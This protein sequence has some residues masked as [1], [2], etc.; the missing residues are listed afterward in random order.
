ML[1]RRRHP[2]FLLAEPLDGSVLLREEVSIERWHGNEL[3]VLSPD[4]GR[5]QER[6]RIEFPGQSWRRYGAVVTESRPLMTEDGVIRHRLRL[7]VESEL[8]AVVPE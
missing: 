6:L 1:G 5:P 8:P 7:R 4:P 3:T 2:R